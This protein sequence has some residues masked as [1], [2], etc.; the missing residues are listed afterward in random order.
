MLLRTLYTWAIMASFMDLKC[1][2]AWQNDSHAVRSRGACIF[3]P[4]YNSVKRAIK[5]SAT[6]ASLDRSSR[7]RTLAMS[8]LSFSLSLSLS[9]SCL[10]AEIDSNRPLSQDEHRRRNP[11]LTPPTPLSHV[12]SPFTCPSPF[13]RRPCSMWLSP[14]TNARQVKMPHS[15]TVWE[16]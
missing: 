8:T 15:V 16:I 13:S 1:A 5:T 14:W 11:Y 10:S 12:S 9:R 4:R 2:S 3:P 6:L 7:R